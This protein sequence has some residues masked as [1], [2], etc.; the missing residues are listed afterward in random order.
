MNRLLVLQHLDREGPGLFSRI[1]QERGMSLNI[2]RLDQGDQLPQL[3][4]GDLLIILGGSMGI[5]DINN[6]NYSWLSKE[7]D[8]I[9]EALVKKIGIIGVCLGAQL[10]AV[11]AGGDVEV[12]V[13]E[14]SSMPL[15]EIGWGSI[16]FEKELNRDLSHC[17]GDTP[18][19]VLHW[20]GDRIILPPFAELIATTNRCKEQFFKIGEYAYGLQFHVEIEEDMLLRWIEEDNEFIRSGLGPNAELI[21]L[22]QQANYGN[23]NLNQRL[24]FLNIIFDLIR[25]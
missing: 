15:P 17:I 8:L 22:D 23:T 5:K 16:F 14:Y 9:K 13:E 12:L 24:S 19:H 10:L 4:K 20:H 11:A 6:P 25:F 2:F 3:L 18:F 1:A 7:I 21:L